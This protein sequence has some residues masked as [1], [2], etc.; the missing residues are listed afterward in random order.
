MRLEWVT[1]LTLQRRRQT[2][3][4]S[5]SKFA[6]EELMIVPMDVGRQYGD[7]GLLCNEEDLV[8]MCAAL[9]YV[10]LAPAIFEKWPAS[11]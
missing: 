11:Y 4:V 2:G 6:G 9:Q 8:V 7:I 10:L 3:I 1:M 5:V